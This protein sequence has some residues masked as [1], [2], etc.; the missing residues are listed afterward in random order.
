MTNA[1]A[2]KLATQLVGDGQEPNMFFVTT[3]PY[4]FE[5]DE[6]GDRESV[7]LDGFDHNY[8]HTKALDTLE[9][10][11]EYYDNIDLDIYMGVGS[12]MI[13]DR[14]TGVIKE[15]ALE[16]IVRVDYVMT[17]QDDTKRFGYK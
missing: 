10:A 14:K 2:K 7:L 3:S 15:K 8:S 12:V 9:E 5:V 16:K 17:E 6:F 11:E 13:E 1:E 4:Y